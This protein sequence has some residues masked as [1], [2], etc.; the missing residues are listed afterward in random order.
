MHEFSGGCD[1]YILVA[2]PSSG[3]ALDIQ[4]VY[5][6]VWKAVLLEKLVAKGVSGTI[7]S[8]VQ[9]FLSKM[10]SMLEVG[11]SRLEVVPECGV[12]QGLPLSLTL[13]LIFI[14]DLLHRL[15]RLDRVHFQSFVDYMIVWV[16]GEFLFG[17]H[18]PQG[19][20]GR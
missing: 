18:G 6:S 11:T 13:F 19:F 4:G 5:N 16:L 12:P 7:I 17:G 10:H 1:A 14:G 20:K 15:A 2:P 8:W 3:V 9:S